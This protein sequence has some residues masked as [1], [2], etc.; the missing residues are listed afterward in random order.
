[1]TP[2]KRRPATP[3][4]QEPKGTAHAPDAPAA[5]P[6]APVP[7]VVVV[8]PVPPAETETGQLVPEDRAA[9]PSPRRPLSL[10]PLPVWP[11]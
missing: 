4:S 3:E 1:M 2:S 11:D 5:P 9:T 10:Y 7:D 6:D 8:V